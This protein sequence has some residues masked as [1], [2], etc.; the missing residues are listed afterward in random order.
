MSNYLR[1]FR[2]CPLAKDPEP[3]RAWVDIVEKKKAQFWKEMGF[4]DAILLPKVGTTYF[5]NMIVAS[6][7][8]WD[9]SHNTFIFPCGM[10]TPT[11]FDIGSIAELR[12][13]REAFD[14]NEM[15][16]NS[17]NF[18]ASKA[19]FTH[20]ISDHYETSIEDLF[21]KEHIAFLALWMS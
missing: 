21:Y 2:S 15:N 6:M 17:I 16:E 3:Y 4:Y 20:Y 11:L 10:L 14:P 13:T 8:F 18:K 1:V 5:Q 19:T 12:Q 7:Y 9:S